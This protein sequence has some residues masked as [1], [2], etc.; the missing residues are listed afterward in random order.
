MILAPSGNRA[1]RDELRCFDWHVSEQE[2]GLHR[3]SGA[4]FTTWLVE[5]DMMAERGQPVLSRVSPAPDGTL[6]THIIEISPKTLLGKAM[7]PLIR[8]GLGK[9]TRDAAAHLKK[10][11]ESAR[12]DNRDAGTS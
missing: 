12:G 6:T 5:T 7:W 11:L 1:V 3:V 4:P 9:Q 2:P 10:L 8:L